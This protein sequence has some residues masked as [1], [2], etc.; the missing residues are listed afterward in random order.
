LKTALKHYASPTLVLINAQENKNIVLG[1][2]LNIQ[3]SNPSN[4]ATV[5]MLE[6]NGNG[7]NAL[8][9][10]INQI[11]T[12]AMRRT[13]QGLL[14]AAGANASGEALLL[15]SAAGTATIGNID[16]TGAKAIEEQLVFASMWAG[17]TRKEAGD[18]ISV[19]ADISYMSN[20]R[21]IKELTGLLAA[22][23]GNS[24]KPFL[25]RRNLYALA[26]KMHPGTLSTFEDNELQIE[27]EQT[28]ESTGSTANFLSLFASMNQN[29]DDTDKNTTET[30]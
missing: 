23:I 21:T 8:S 2:A 1:G 3:S 11:K 22:N 12:D 15:R 30:P 17:A 28:P 29:D 16:E 13:V 18:R 14:D 4:P 25:S 5:S 24:G 27:Q 19:E 20:P 26:E 7:L 9:A 10:S 6:M